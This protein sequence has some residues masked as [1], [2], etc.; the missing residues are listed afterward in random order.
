MFPYEART[1]TTGSGVPLAAALGAA[2]A[3]AGAVLPPHAATRTPTETRSESVVRARKAHL[4]RRRKRRSIVIPFDHPCGSVGRER[5]RRPRLP[6][7][8]HLGA[9]QPLGIPPPPARGRP[10][11]ARRHGHRRRLGR[12]FR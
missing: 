4:R 3:A 8:D 1:L 6:A 11:A 9:L 7:R 10:R 12:A 5:R 2:V